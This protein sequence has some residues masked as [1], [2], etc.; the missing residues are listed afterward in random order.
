MKV[1]VGKVKST[2]FVSLPKLLVS[3]RKPMHTSYAFVFGRLYQGYV[4][5]IWVNRLFDFTLW[6]Y[7]P[8]GG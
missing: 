3:V 5:I 8:K 7:K 2:A 1:K 6:I 4:G